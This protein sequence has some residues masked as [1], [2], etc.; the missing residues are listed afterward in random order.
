MDEVQFNLNR[1]EGLSMEVE[2]GSS[3]EMPESNPDSPEGAAAGD[4]A[5]AEVGRLEELQKLALMAD[6]T[7]E[8]INSVL[9]ERISEIG[10]GVDGNLQRGESDSGRSTMGAGSQEGTWQGGVLGSAR[11]RPLREPVARS[12]PILKEGKGGSIRGGHIRWSDDVG[13]Q[14]VKSP[15]RPQLGVSEDKGL[16]GWAPYVDSSHKVR[17][18]TPGK[19]LLKERVENFSRTGVHP[20]A[21][22]LYEGSPGP[23]NSGPGANSLDKFLHGTKNLEVSGSPTGG[24]VVPGIGTPGPEQVSRTWG[25]PH[26]EHGSRPGVESSGTWNGPTVPVRK[27]QKKAMKYDGKS[28]WLDYLRQFEITAQ[29]NGW[30][31]VEKAMELAT[32]L[33]GAARDVLTNL[34]MQECVDFDAL[35]Q[36]LTLRFEP[37]GQHEVHEN[38][39]RNRRRKRS[40]TI[41]ELLQDVKRLSKRAYPTATPET[42]QQIAKSAFI[43]ALNDEKQELFVKSRKPV[44]VDDAA[45]DA[46]SYETHINSRVKP[47]KEFVRHQTVEEEEPQEASRA[48]G[49]TGGLND[50]LN[51]LMDKMDSLLTQISARRR[52]PPVDKSKVLCYRCHNYGHY[53]STC[54]EP[55]PGPSTGTGSGN[56]Q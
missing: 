1:E 33:D 9:A 41:P 27:F 46:L 8:Q 23:E 40:E 2:V 50:G 56:D 35:Q 48:I 14:S 43:T 28:S 31:K 12:T 13:V 47:G 11:G 26:D 37:Q 54:P 34:S 10:G 17:P 21:R 16:G 15:P 5:P 32:C 29:L 22:R 51:A 18:S 49:A 42:I 36:A 7:Y 55:A 38:D 25:G 52:S 19:V 39:L 6:E 3:P 30:S 45:H 20:Y 4:G 24:P 53:Q 44:S